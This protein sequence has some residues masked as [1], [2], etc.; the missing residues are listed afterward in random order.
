MPGL[1]YVSRL[2]REIDSHLTGVTDLD[3]RVSD[4]G[5]HVLYATSRSGG[6]ISA[7]SVSETGQANLLDHQS[8]ATDADTVEF[9]TMGD[10][11]YVVTIAPQEDSTRLYALDSAGRMTGSATTLP[12]ESTAMNSLVQMELGQDSFLFCADAESGVLDT[13]RVGADGSLTAIAPGTNAGEVT[14]LAKASVGSNQFLV[15]ADADGKHV[16]SFLVQSDGSLADGGVAGADQGLGVA[17]ISTMDHVTLPDGNYVV[18]AARDSSSLSVLRLD[19]SGALIPVDHVI[20][21]LNTRFQNV[22]ALETVALDNRVFVI[23]G[24]ADDGVSVFELLPGG[25][26]MLHDTLPDSFNT[27]LANVSSIGATAVGGELHIFVGS[28]TE[29]GVTQLALDPGT[30]GS[31]RFGTSGNNTMTGTDAG[32]VMTGLAGNDALSGG[33]GDDILM[34]GAGRDTLTGGAGRDV[35][36]LAS[37]GS[38]DEIRDFTPGEDRID[39]TEWPMLRNLD[40]IEFAATSDGAILTFGTEQLRI[41]SADGLP[42][43]EQDVLTDDLI[44]LTRIPASAPDPVDPVDPVDT[45]ID[46]LGNAQS[47]LL[48]ANGLNNLLLGYAGADT[49]DGGFGD[50]TLN[51]GVGADRLIGGA[52]GRDMASYLGASTGL[53]AD[54]AFTHVNTGDAAGDSYSGIEDLQGS[55]LDDDLRGDAANNVVRGEGGDDLLYG[56]DGDDTLYGGAGDDILVGGAGADHMDGGAGWNRISYWTSDVDLM[57]DLQFTFVNTGIAAG[58]SYDQVQDIQGSA[59]NDQIRGNN[60]N[61]HIWGNAGDDIL[62]GRDGD[63]RLF[64]HLGDDTLYGNLGADLINGGDGID[65]VSYWTAVE[66]VTADMLDQSVNTGEAAGDTYVELENLNGSSHD[67]IL[68]GDNANNG[69]WGAAG[70][71]LIEGRGG[72][73]TLNGHLGMDTLDGGAGNDL[74]QGGSEADTFVFTE[75][76]DTV[77]SFENDLDL[78]QIDDAL[79]GGGAIST[80]QLIDR[81]ATVVNGNTVL[82]FGGG[83]RLTISGLGNPDLLLDDIVI[84]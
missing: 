55:D 36:V 70:D 71:D 75:G 69:I 24:G 10:A 20:D 63:D 28:S 82:D 67:D 41:Y 37:D 29:T 77:Q 46:F 51:G 48:E 65:M 61:N 72:N 1:R 7:F 73:D 81:Y 58:D 44:N 42:L 52:G 49:L 21:D 13:F 84:F 64:G 56:R 57:A 11:T 26:L 12:G 47:N 50:D 40:Q 14:G 3:I 74:L 78:I 32:E 45:Q 60:Y 83:D 62:L 31:T 68:R 53:L 30:T 5:D 76:A 79:W 4:N 22:T 80:A 39:L 43:S 59:G 16:R 19:A 35:F 2:E 33:G 17:G 15:M 9:L 54:L 6:A 38:Y 34:D 25:R 23:V 8:L 27:T 66:G 18:V